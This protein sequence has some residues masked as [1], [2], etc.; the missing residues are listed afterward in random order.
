MIYWL[1]SHIILN[2]AI[3]INIGYLVVPNTESKSCG[4]IVNNGVHPQWWYDRIAVDTKD[5]LLYDLNT[6]VQPIS[7]LSY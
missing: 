6:M 4:C 5:R 1:I 2:L 7:K 3:L